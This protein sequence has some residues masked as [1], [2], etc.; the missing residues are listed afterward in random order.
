VL[1]GDYR[2]L[3]F[4]SDSYSVS[5]KDGAA[6]LTVRR[7]GDKGIAAHVDYAYGGRFGQSRNGLHLE[8]RDTGLCPYELSKTITIRSDNWRVQNDD[9]KFEVF[10][11][12]PGDGHLGRM[13]TAEV[14]ILDD[15]RPG[16]LDPI[17]IR[18]RP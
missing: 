18:T 8:S 11:N 6:V 7:G 4:S 12:A 15:E 1:N 9:R 10:L 5:E 17:F 2:R 3:E 14:T 16:S 13:K